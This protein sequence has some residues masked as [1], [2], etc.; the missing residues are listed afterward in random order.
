METMNIKQ[1]LY[2]RILQTFTILSMRKIIK[3]IGCSRKLQ[4][5]KNVIYMA[6]GK[7]MEY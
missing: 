5:A 4:T 2:W 1:F 6:I 7:Q 3:N